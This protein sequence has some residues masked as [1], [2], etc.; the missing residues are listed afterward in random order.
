MFYGTLNPHWHPAPSAPSFARKGKH[1]LI[2]DNSQSRAEITTQPAASM[3]LI[4]H[5]DASVGVTVVA[6]PQ[7]PLV[8]LVGLQWAPG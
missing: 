8:M 5:E 6:G 1:E 2:E 3:R 7:S 4:V